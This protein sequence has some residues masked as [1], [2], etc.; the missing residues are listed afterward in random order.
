MHIHTPILTAG[1]CEGGGEVFAVYPASDDLPKDECAEKNDAYLATS[2]EQFDSDYYF[3]KRVY[4]TVSGQLH[5]EAI[6]NGISQVYN[7][8]P[9]FR[10][11]TGRSRRHLSEFWMVEA[12]VA[13]ANDLINDVVKVAESL[14][15]HVLSSILESNSADLEVFANLSKDN[16]LSKHTTD[17]DLL[18][19]IANQ[20]NP[21]VIMTYQEAMDILLKNESQFQSKPKYG[22]GLGSEHELF[23]V[24]RHCNGVPVFVIEWPASTKPFYSRLMSSHHN[25]SDVNEELVSAVDLLFPKVGELCGGALREHRTSV[26]RKKMEECSGETE[27]EL[28]SVLK[29]YLDL[30]EIGGSAPTGGFGLGFERLIQFAL[31]IN[32]IRDALPFPRT[33]HNCRL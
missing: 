28:L 7:F 9:A 18:E 6:C 11:E 33:P 31:G 21:Y 24:E 8:S 26:L 12:E 16:N 19:S 4:M 23:L 15:K 5:L 1:D 10:A 27:N 20:H 17:L 22:A 32:N 2:N 30:R 29:W 13:F 3:N 25:S 14:V